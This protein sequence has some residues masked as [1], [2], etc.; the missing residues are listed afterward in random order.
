MV[1][2]NIHPA[3]CQSNNY[4]SLLITED[5]DSLINSINTIPNAQW[6]KNEYNYL[7]FALDKTSQTLKHFEVLKEAVNRFS[8][9]SMFQLKLSQTYYELGDYF[10]AQPL[11]EQLILTFPERSAPKYQLAKIYAFNKKY[12]NA[13]D[14]FNTLYENDTT[15][16]LYLNSLIECYSKSDSLN[17]AISLSNKYLEFSPENQKIAFQLCLL[18]F[19]KEIYDPV[20]ET[21]DM[22]LKQ[23][24]ASVTFLQLKAKALYMAEEYTKSSQLYDQLLLYGDSTTLTLR[25]HGLSKYRTNDYESAVSSLTL[26]YNLFPQD[27][28]SCY[29]IA[30]SYAKLSYGEQKAL[31]YFEWALELLNYDES[32]ATIYNQMGDVYTSLKDYNNAQRYYKYALTAEP[33]HSTNLYALATLNDFH[34]KNKKDALAYYN[35]Y[36]DALNSDTT[37]KDSSSISFLKREETLEYSK[38]RAVQLKEDLFFGEK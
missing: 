36:I 5:Y 13:L 29:Y 35:R 21:C 17:K 9:D 24:S 4:N 12:E 6:S 38:R 3:S 30:K 2:I 16:L 7:L 15:N 18:Y 11:L 19:K 14:L 22:M 1:M 34:I 27:Y 25:Y 23:D 10:N 37:E 28:T 8:A 26:V 32:V 20:I 33:S 31:Q